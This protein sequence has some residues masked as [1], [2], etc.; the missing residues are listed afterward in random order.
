MVE[1]RGTKWNFDVEMDSGIPG[2]R[3][4]SRPD[5]EMPTVT[6]REE[7]HTVPPPAPPPEEHVH[8]MRGQGVHAMQDVSRCLG[9]EATRGIVG[10][11]DT[12]PLDPSSSTT[13]PNPKRSKT[14]S[15]TDNENLANQTHVVAKTK[16]VI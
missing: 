4:T 7:I 2:P 8:E 14:T 3:A 11:P 12:R 6:A 1:G 15:V 16:M 5:E 10:D 9:R 13:D